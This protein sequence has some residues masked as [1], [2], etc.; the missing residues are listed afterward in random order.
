MRLSERRIGGAGPSAGI[1]PAWPLACALIE[2]GEQERA[3]E[4]LRPLAGDEIEG[5]MPVERTFFWETLSLAELDGGDPELAETFVRRAE[6]DADSLDLAL[7]LGVARRC[8]AALSLATGDAEGAARQAAESIASFRKI[9]AR[10]EVAFSRHLEGRALAASGDRQAAI[11]VLREA[12]AEL[13]ACGSNRERDGARRELRRLGARAHVRGPGGA[14]SG[15]DSLTNRER[16]IAALVERRLTNK[17]IAAELV[18]SEK[19]IESHLRNVFAKLGAASRVEV[20]RTMERAPMEG[21]G[22]QATA[23]GGG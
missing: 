13:D 23:D 4:M 3:R 8:R 1:G 22:G 19:T 2:S 9:G 10:I 7:P 17:E 21:A 15:V 16:Q 18:L 5:A 11:K 6:R 14:G 20:A 12:E